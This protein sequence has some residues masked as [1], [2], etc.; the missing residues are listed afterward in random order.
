MKTIKLKALIAVALG[1]ALS[2]LGNTPARAEISLTIDGPELVR[3][4]Q[5]ATYS[6]LGSSNANDVLD[7]F[8]IILNASGGPGLSFSSTQSSDF[9]TDSDYVFFNRSGNAATNFP[10][11]ALSDGSLS[12]ADFSDDQ[13]ASPNP[14]M[15]D[16]FT[17]G[18]EPRLFG[19]F[20]VDAVAPADFSIAFDPTTSFNDPNFDLIS[21]TSTPLNVT[22]VPEPSS[23]L[24]MLVVVGAIAWRRRR[25]IRWA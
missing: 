2:A 17:F 8:G 4:G 20:S 1:L 12:I 3:V 25:M 22:A 6:V 13:S 19:Q 18:A 16:P 23:L 21:F 9:L 5:S 14:G 15:S 10:A 11:T 24:A 7:G